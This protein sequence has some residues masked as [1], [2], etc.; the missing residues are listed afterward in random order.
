MKNVVG[1]PAHTLEYMVQRGIWKED[2]KD[3]IMEIGKEGGHKSKSLDEY[4][5]RFI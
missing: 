5:K 1:R 4:G 3:N 2:W